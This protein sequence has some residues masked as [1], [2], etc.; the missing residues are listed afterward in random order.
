MDEPDGGADARDARER[1]LRDTL[2][3]LEECARAIDEAT[4]RLKAGEFDDLRDVGRDI[5]E[6]R[7]ATELVLEERQRVT[8]WLEAGE[9]A[10]GTAAIDFDAARRDIGSRL[11]R[12]GRGGHPERVP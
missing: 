5:R 12:L 2:K 3:H 10:G 7:K 1:L 9:A 4:A 6:L 11:A 8:R